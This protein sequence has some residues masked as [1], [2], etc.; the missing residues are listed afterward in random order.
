VFARIIVT[1]HVS[2]IHSHTDDHWHQIFRFSRICSNI[3]LLQA[4]SL[5]RDT[6]G[7]K[8][9][10]NF[11][12]HIMLRSTFI[13]TPPFSVNNTID[14]KQGSVNSFII[15]LGGIVLTFSCSDV[16]RGIVSTLPGHHILKM[17]CQIFGWVCLKEVIEYN[18]VVTF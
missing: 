3:L 13:H 1:Q 14:Y 15:V 11:L 7:Q 4:P 18:G 9:F 5:F 2:F 10:I 8:V 17:G 12:G 6:V 16:S